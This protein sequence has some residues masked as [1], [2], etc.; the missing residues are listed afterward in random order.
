V[1]RKTREKSGGGKAKKL[2]IGINS[3][4]SLIHW[5]TH[6]ADLASGRLAGVSLPQ[7]L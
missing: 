5:S 7:M 6:A 4:L 3:K 2:G 1:G